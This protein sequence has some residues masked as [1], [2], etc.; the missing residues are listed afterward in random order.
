MKIAICSDSH[1]NLVNIST[2]LL[3]C[4]KNKIKTI[5]HCGDWC[6]PATLRFFRENFQGKIYGVFGNV[7]GGK[8]DMMIKAV[9]NDTELREDEFSLELDGIKIFLTHFPD[10]AKALALTNKFNIVFYGHN[11]KPSIEKIGETFLVNPGTLAGM[12]TR[13]TFAIYDTATHK[14]DLKIL[15][16]LK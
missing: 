7:H 3:Y 15:D 10:T 8:H 16:C 11:H 5:L 6:A 4:G 2:F 9:E 12:F 14:I 13:A 1:D